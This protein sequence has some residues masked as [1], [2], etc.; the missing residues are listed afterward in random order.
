[1]IFLP[2]LLSGIGSGLSIGSQFLGGIQRDRVADINYR[3]DTTNAAIA[4]ENRL[5]E[6]EI[7][8]VQNEARLSTAEVNYQLAMSEVEFGK[9]NAERLRQFA[10]SRH[11]SSRE[12][13]RRQVRRFDK[14]QGRQKAL[15]G[16]SGVSFEGSPM[17][18]L[19]DTVGE[20]TLTLQDMADQANFER[21]RGMAEAN[22]EEFRWGNL[23]VS[24]FHD[25]ESALSGARIAEEMAKLGKISASQQYNADILGARFSR[26]S[27]HD[28]AR[29]QRLS[30][31]GMVFSGMADYYSDQY[32]RNQ[33]AIV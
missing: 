13:I 23:E 18:N 26:M 16:A 4:R 25:R 29:G 9:R 10:E 8:R 19:A 33:N 1:M 32:D 28:V 11:E 3:I 24:A 5:A 12:E 22:L 31:I 17:E 27:Q 21:D 6:I 15:I 20:M 2:T 7:A 14:F 30:S